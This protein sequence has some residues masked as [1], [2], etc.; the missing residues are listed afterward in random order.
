M[1]VKTFL[2]R[3]ADEPTTLAEILRVCAEVGLG[4][5]V[6]VFA[7]ATRSGVA[8]FDLA[9]GAEFW[10]GT[11]T[12]WLFGIDYGRTHP[13]ALRQM[14]GK[15]N[16][17]I[18]I[19][20]GRWV[21]ESPGFV[22]RRDFH[23]KM[24]IVSNAAVDRFGMVVGSGNFSSNGLRRSREAGATVIVEGQD[25]YA[26]TFRHCVSNVNELWDDATA[27][28]E[29]VDD[30]EERW[31]ESFGS[32]I[33]DVEI[34]V[35]EDRDF[36]FW[37]EAGYVT[38]NRG[39]GRPG[40]QIDLPRG[41]GR[42]FGLVYPQNLQRNSVIGEITFDTPTGDLVTRSLRFGNNSMEKITLPIPETHGFDLYDGKV[43]VFRRLE[44][45]FK[46]QALEPEDFDKSFGKRLNQV[47][48]MGSGRL[49][50]RIDEQ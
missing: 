5:F 24:S 38:R 1:S 28:E 22:P 6:G 11:P 45:A 8:S 23:A 33:A 31:H 37:I 34:D 47:R 20:D 25:A 49:Y 43:L 16:T 39:P 4:E 46:I 3:G 7:Y 48:E 32:E 35:D 30:Y 41:M 10:N 27:I 2:H 17:E 29:I 44:N 40:N 9:V 36:L 15:A 14:C 50:G 42:Y 18:R 19:V 13:E 21:L 26:A 12:R